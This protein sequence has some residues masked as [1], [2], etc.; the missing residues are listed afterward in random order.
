[1]MH[2]KAVVWDVDGTLAETERDGHRV[3]FNR[4]FAAC[5]LPWHWTEA[6]YGEL[7]GVTGGY[8]RLLRD[9]C[10]RPDAPRGAARRD[11]LARRIHDMKNEIYPE[12]LR[13]VGLPLRDGVLEL[14]HECRSHGVRM[15]IATTTSR[16]CVEALL[17]LHLGPGWR[18]W[19]DALVCGEDVQHKKPD[20]EVYVRALLQVRVCPSEAVAIEDS[21]QGA[22]AARAVDM[23]VVLTRS[24][25]FADAFF[26]GVTAIGPGLDQ[27]AG[28]QPHAAPDATGSA[29]IRLADIDRWIAGARRP[30]A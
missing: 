30:H 7:L 12:L 17:R 10:E 4:A 28:W 1:M 9:M 15:G 20:P 19:F 25:Y 21:P 22:A 27:R 16:V 13:H 5:G 24:R 18:E 23:P 14:M 8:E 2:V 6:R 3:A 29:G 26:P 11:A